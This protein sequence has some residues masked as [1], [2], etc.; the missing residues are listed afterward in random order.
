MNTNDYSQGGC[1]PPPR[2]RY[3]SP[4]Q[5]YSL[6]RYFVGKG[7]KAMSMYVNSPPLT[8]DHQEVRDIKEEGIQMLRP[9]CFGFIGD[10]TPRGGDCQRCGRLAMASVTSGERNIN[11]IHY[12]CRK[13]MQEMEVRNLKKIVGMKKA[14]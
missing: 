8:R 1:G 9:I 14:K 2:A 5:Y 6:L 7:A 13:K 11:T 4:T 10:R 12:V 3:L